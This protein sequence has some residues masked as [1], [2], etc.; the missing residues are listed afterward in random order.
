MPNIQVI[1]KTYLDG[2]EVGG[3]IDLRIELYDAD[4]GRVLTAGRHV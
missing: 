2:S 1:S 3:V 4:T